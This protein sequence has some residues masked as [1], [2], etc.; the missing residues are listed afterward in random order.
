MRYGCLAI[1]VARR[2]GSCLLEAAM[3]THE[4]RVTLNSRSECMC[5][6]THI[7]TH[8]TFFLCH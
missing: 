2:A 3:T 4:R 7:H 6:P 8:K 5:T 1:E